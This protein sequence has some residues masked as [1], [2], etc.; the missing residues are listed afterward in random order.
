MTKGN[1][2][3][4]HGGYQRSQEK[5]PTTTMIAAAEME[6]IQKNHDSCY[7]EMDADFEIS[8]FSEEHFCPREKPAPE[9]EL[10]FFNAPYD[11]SG[12]FDC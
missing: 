11:D 9:S 2:H 10:V 12:F 8:D 4:M 6:E 1:S 5:K 3:K 7:D